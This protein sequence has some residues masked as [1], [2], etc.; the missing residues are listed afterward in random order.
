MLHRVFG[1]KQAGV[2][3]RARPGA[4]LI[5]ASGSQIALIRTPKGYF[6]PGGGLE[7]GETHEA[8]TLRECLEET[9]RRVQVGECLCSAESYLLHER[10]GP[11]HPVQHYYMGAFLEAVCFPVES[12]HTLVWLPCETTAGRMKAE[13]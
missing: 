11:F 5:A 4:Y 1:A 10:I 12:D 3:Y 13:Q 2:S 8:C 6:L 9:G 7:Q